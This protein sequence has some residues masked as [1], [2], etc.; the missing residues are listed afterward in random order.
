MK[1]W[2]FFGHSHLAVLQRA[3]DSLS[4]KPDFSK[5]RAHFF[6]IDHKNIYEFFSIVDG[7]AE[8]SDK[9]IKQINAIIEGAD[10]VEMMLSLAGNDHSII[11][12][13]KTEHD[14]LVMGA[15]P[16]TAKQQNNQIL[17]HDLLSAVFEERLVGVKQL[18]PQL[19]VCFQVKAYM[20]ASPPPLID[21]QRIKNHPGV[22]AEILEQ[23]GVNRSQNRL[24]LWQIQNQVM[25]QYA[26]DNLIEFISN[27]QE[28][29]DDDGFLSE[30]FSGNDPTHGNDEYGILVLKNLFALQSAQ[31]KGMNITEKVN[32]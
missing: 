6:I 9:L 11:G 7:I 13:A 21:E 30:N 17:S 25:Q 4:N 20:L 15:G 14:Y 2:I 28:I 3:W 10:D 5:H 1:D 19:M 29:F 26:N 22:F 24:S 32:D 12:L 8:P 27:P 18:I 16:D 31:T 23:F